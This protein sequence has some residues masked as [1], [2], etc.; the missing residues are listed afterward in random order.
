MTYLSGKTMTE[1]RNKREKTHK[2]QD[3][4]GKRHKTLIHKKNPAKTETRDTD[5]DTNTETQRQIQA[6]T[7]THKKNRHTDR[8]TDTQKKQ[9]QRPYNPKSV[10]PN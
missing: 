5:T 1:I 6:Q 2:T 9:K 7:W 4:K 8:D 10:A 3:T